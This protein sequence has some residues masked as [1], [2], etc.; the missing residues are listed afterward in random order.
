[1]RFENFETQFTKVSSLEI[2]SHE[3]ILPQGIMNFTNGKG[4]YAQKYR[5]RY[6]I[7]AFSTRY[8]YTMRCNIV[9]E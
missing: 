9:S 2:F 7:F 3:N 8:F 1:M 5:K 4:L 6:L